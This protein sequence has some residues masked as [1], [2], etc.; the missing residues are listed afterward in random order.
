MKHSKTILASV[1]LVGAVATSSVFAANMT[2][3][4]NKM[5]K[6]NPFTT[7]TVIKALADKGITAPTVEEAKAF[8]TKM[9]AAHEAQEKL[10]D[11]DKAGLKTLRES[12]QKQERDYLRSKGVTLPSEEEIA[13][14]KQIREVLG[15]QMKDF[16][17]PNGEGKGGMM[18]DDKM[19][20]GNKMSGEGRGFGGGRGNHEKGA[21]IPAT[22]AMPAT[23]VN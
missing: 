18:K 1:L 15:E 23:P 4:T 19:M 20:K 11:T 21:A 2:G 3:V 14:M 12:F 17:G 8:E 9:Q 5:A 7:E 13:K 10:S 16:R 6:M 22:P